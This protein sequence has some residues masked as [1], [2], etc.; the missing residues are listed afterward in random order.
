LFVGRQSKLR[1]LAVVLKGS[2]AGSLVSTAAITGLGGVGKTQLAIEFVHRYGQFFSG[3]VFW[4]SF[5]DATAI[6]SKVASLG[7]ADA[8]NLR[9]DFDKLT[10]EI[11]VRLVKAAWQ[12]PLPRLLVFDQCEEE[13]LLRQWRPT[14][15]GCRILLTS[16][17][18]EWDKELG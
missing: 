3:G 12:S 13:G 1:E 14:T 7:G 11:Q 10:L 17:R 16:R 15:G 18:A 9:P 4:I 2:K 6:S 5:A 8:L